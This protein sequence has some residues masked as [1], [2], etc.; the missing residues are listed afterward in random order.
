MH[1]PPPVDVVAAEQG[2]IRSVAGPDDASPIKREFEIDFDG[3]RGVSQVEEP[4]LAHFVV[5]AAVGLGEQEVSS[6]G[7]KVEFRFEAC[8]DLRG[9]ADRSVVD[10]RD[11]IFA[12]GSRGAG[13]VWCER[14]ISRQ[15]RDECFL[16]AVL[17]HAVA[18]DGIASR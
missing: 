15:T 7:R 4:E 13:L 3:T 6:S 16:R 11:E 17:A 12:S 9:E 5:E 1:V 18:S 10:E 2:E 8:G 14:T